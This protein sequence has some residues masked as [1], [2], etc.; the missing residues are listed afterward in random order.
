MLK[1]NKYLLI[2]QTNKS[3]KFKKIIIKKIDI[4]PCVIDSMLYLII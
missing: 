4:Q 1:I 3:L 2:A